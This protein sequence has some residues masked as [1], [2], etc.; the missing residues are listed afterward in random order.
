MRTGAH[1]WVRKALGIAM[2]G[3]QTGTYNSPRMFLVHI[4][5]DA[6]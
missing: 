1:S 6:D 2:D 5:D 4:T 3:E